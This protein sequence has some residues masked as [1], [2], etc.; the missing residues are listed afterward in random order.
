MQMGPVP[1]RP[2]PTAIGR[3]LPRIGALRLLTLAFLLAACGPAAGPAPAA[4]QTASQTA[5]TP[6]P[7]AQA[8]SAASAA[9]AAP[10]PFVLG[11]S[12]ISATN[13]NIQAT[14]DAGLFLKYG[15]D[16]ELQY[17]GGGTNSMAALVS[18]TVPVL[19]GG[20]PAFVSATLEGADVALIAIQGNRFDYYFVTT[21]DI[22]RPEDL[23]GKV[24]SGTRK[25][26]LADTAIRLVLRQWGLEPDREVAILP[27]GAG[28]DARTV[29]LLNG[30]TVG[31]V[32]NVPLPAAIA[33]GNF[34][35]LADLTKLD[36]AYANN[37]VAARRADLAQEPDFYERFLRGYV[38]GIHYFKTHLEEGA[39]AITEWAKIDDPHQASAAYEFYA[40]Q[41][42]RVPVPAAGGLLCNPMRPDLGPAFRP[43]ITAGEGPQGHHRIHVR[44]GPVHAA[45]L[46][47]R[48]DHQL[49]RA[50][51]RP[52]ADRIPGGSKLRVLQLREPRFQ[53]RHCAVPL[54]RR[55]FRRERLRHR[56]R[57]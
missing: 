26:A 46:Q 40:P 6:Q 11:L 55:G 28:N 5:A 10:V 13:A 4:S 47:P 56:P 30:A 57:P 35:V 20:A 21:P 29:A 50:L 8:A 52:A 1:R 51:H 33:Q 23:R 39:R 27:A 45:A 18:G 38:E 22:R 54:L 24:L 25:G 14:K 2:W 32:L 53:I 43:A 37:G 41:L 34:H 44:A 48:F 16:A 3:L 36:I 12:S 19:V 15:L 31:T 7:A 17:I 49:V 9:A 42:Q